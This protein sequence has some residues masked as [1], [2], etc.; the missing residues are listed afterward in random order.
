[1]NKHS[2]IGYM[3]ANWWKKTRYLLISKTLLTSLRS[4]TEAC[5]KRTEQ[6]KLHGNQKTLII[7]SFEYS[8]VDW[9]PVNYYYMY[10]SELFITLSQDAI[11]KSKPNGCEYVTIFKNYCLCWGVKTSDSATQ[12]PD[13]QS[14]APTYFKHRA[15]RWDSGV[16]SR[17][18]AFADKQPKGLLRHF[19]S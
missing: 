7:L 14:N 19:H 15:G 11:R 18:D 2:Q 17:I 10:L 4:S 3:F 9:M 6:R 13:V 5:G 8:G 16:I 1:M 12:C